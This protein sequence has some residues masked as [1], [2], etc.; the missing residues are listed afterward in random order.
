MH[1]GQCFKQRN[2]L[3]KP[4]NHFKHK[5]CPDNSNGTGCWFLKG[6]QVFVIII[7]TACNILHSLLCCL[8]FPQIL[9]NFPENLC[10]FCPINVHSPAFRRQEDPQHMLILA[11]TSAESSVQQCTSL[12]RGCNESLQHAD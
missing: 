6:K 12:Q 7:N 2:S 9:S 1:L 4:S 3:P 10:F 8:F 5:L 11:N